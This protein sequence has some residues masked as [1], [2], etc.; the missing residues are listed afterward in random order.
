MDAPNANKQII[1]DLIQTVW[2]HGEIEALPDFW[3]ADCVN[4]AM[5]GTENRGLDALQ[6]YHE[7]FLA[8]I[9]AFSDIQIEILQ[10]IAEGDRV[11]TYLDSRGRHTGAFYGVPPTNKAVSLTSIRIDHMENGKIAEHWSIA[12]MASLMQ[13][14]GETA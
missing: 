1:R 7:S 3:T 4:H 2:I 12:D 11:V 6:A 8:A 14:M 10:Q 13:Q 9:S 5:P